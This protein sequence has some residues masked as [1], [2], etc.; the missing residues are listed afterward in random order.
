MNP[1]ENR[2]RMMELMFDCF[3][4][5]LAYV[6]MQAVL[7]LYAAGRSTGKLTFIYSV[8]VSKYTVD[9]VSI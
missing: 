2:Q 8:D 3:T 4:V 1:L 9:S 5:P 7:A 6:T